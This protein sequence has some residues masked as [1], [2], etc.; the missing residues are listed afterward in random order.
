MQPLG[1]KKIKKKHLGQKNHPTSWD[2]IITQPLG[3]KKNMQ[4]LGTKKI[5]LSIGPIVS[6]LV[7]KAPNCSKWHQIGPNGSKYVRI[8]PNGSKLVQAFPN[9][10]KWIKMGQLGLNRSKWVKMGP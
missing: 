10:T 1:T 2:Q 3:Q 5:T 8:G 7:H 4:P 9:G 6:N